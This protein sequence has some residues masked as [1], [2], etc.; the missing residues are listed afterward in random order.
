M[1]VCCITASQSSLR[2]SNQEAVR[3]MLEAGIKLIQYREK[4]LSMFHKY[5]ECQA[6]ET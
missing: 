2:R 4:D 3:Q 1:D 5:W 6:F